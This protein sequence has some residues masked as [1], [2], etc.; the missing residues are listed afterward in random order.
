[1]RCVSAG[2]GADTRLSAFLRSAFPEE[3][4]SRARLDRAIKA[5]CITLNGTPALTLSLLVRDGDVVDVDADKLL[6]REKELS[7]AK[8]YQGPSMFESPNLLFRPLKF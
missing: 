6:A 8:A 4:S 7:R 1:M 5:G 2:L 3:F